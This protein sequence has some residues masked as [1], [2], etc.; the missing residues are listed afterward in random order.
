MK[1]NSAF[2][3]RSV[4][5]A[6]RFLQTAVVIDD[7][8]FFN[9]DGKPEPQIIEL[10]PPPTPTT[11][12]IG[13]SSPT[14]PGPVAPVLERPEELPMDPDPHGINARLIIESFAQQG[15]VCSVLRRTVGE[16]L[17]S[18]TDRA[19][20]LFLI[21]DILIVDWQVHNPNGSDSTEETLKFIKAAVG[22]S[23]R[24]TPQKLRLIVIYTG[25]SNLLEVATQVGLCLE[26][27]ANKPPRKDGDFAFQTDALRVV[28]LGKPSNKRV[29]DQRDQQVEDDSGLCTRTIEE[30]TE[31]TAGLVSNVALDSL[32]QVRRATHGLLTRFGP[33]LDAAFLTHRA[34]LDPP[35]EGDE[36]LI[37]LIV[38]ELEAILENTVSISKDF[39]SEESIRQWLDTRPN[40]LPS[41]DDSPQIDTEE[42]ARK[43]VKEICLTGVHEH[44]TYSVPNQPSWIK[45]L[46]KDKGN[47]PIEKL[48]SLIAAENMTGADEKLEILMSFRTRYSNSLPM[49]TL[50][51]LLQTNEG[52]QTH[53]YWLCLQPACDCFIRND[54]PRRAF[55]LLRI[56][57]VA[58]KF[59]IVAEVGSAFVRLRWDAKP[60][61]IQMFEFEAN[62]QV[63]TV[64]ARSENGTL[65]FSSISP[66]KDFSWIAELKF[67]QAQRVV[68]ALAS[69]TARVGL[70]ESEWI[71][72]N[73]K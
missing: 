3:E 57:V 22:E 73:A 38:S 8:A 48:T 53:G 4:T 9:A 58:D 66:V 43:A 52:N 40:H 24:D 70:T 31:M 64:I 15:I 46:A 45:K 55:P 68:Q 47:A 59:N 19:H 65:L 10:S 13:D 33:Q 63:E 60:Y 35:S 34:L 12:P 27:A 56:E 62:S 20:L 49:L 50:G 69:E 17:T 2:F 30:F 51:T 11:A 67:P 36:H 26:T 61:K 32:A 21:A 72:R 37:P 16:D 1:R 6:K 42:K 29:Q 25:A 23:L 71:R 39:L 18:P 14:I 28:V 5:I 7:R 54:G 41:F 44:E